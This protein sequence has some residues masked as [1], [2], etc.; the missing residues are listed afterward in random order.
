[1][2]DRKSFASAISRRSLLGG[3]SVAPGLGALGTPSAPNLADQCAE[4]LT[5]KLEID[6]LSLRWARL[7]AFIIHQAVRQP[8]TTEMNEIDARLRLLSDEGDRR[9]DALS[10]RPART[11]HEVACKLAV[12]AHRMADEGGPEHDIVADAVR[13]MTALTSPSAAT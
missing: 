10:K 2:P 9:L 12:A 11:L 1:M 7:E 13:A 5:L 3:A 4:W 6:Q 8:C